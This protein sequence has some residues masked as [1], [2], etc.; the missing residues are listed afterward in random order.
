MH[1]FRRNQSDLLCES[2]D[3]AVELSFNVSTCRNCYFCK[4]TVLCGW[5]T[6]VSVREK[7]N[8]LIL[9]RKLV[10]PEHYI[11]RGVAVWP[12]YTN[13]ISHGWLRSYFNDFLLLWD[14]GNVFEDRSPG[15]KVYWNCSYNMESWRSSGF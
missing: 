12:Y 6:T 4:Y 9:R 3:E 13:V 15:D 10:C 2:D 11:V 8:L 5:I 7:A 14:S 1:T